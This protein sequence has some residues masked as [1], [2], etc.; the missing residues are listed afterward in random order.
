M[1]ASMKL[2]Q[3]NIQTAQTLWGRLS[4]QQKADYMVLVY[5]ILLNRHP[6]YKQIFPKELEPVRDNMTDTINYLLQ[7]LEQPEKMQTVFDC[8]GLKHK[9]MQ[10]TA[11]MFPH[12]VSCKVEALADFFGGTLSNADLKHWENTMNFLAKGIINAYPS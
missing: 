10:I 11:D 8:L 1:S 7:H 12:M 4:A 5:R 2:D 6:E 3:S 9:E